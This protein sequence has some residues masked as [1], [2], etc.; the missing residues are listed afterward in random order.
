MIEIQQVCKRHRDSE[1]LRGAS[2]SVSK[3]QV[4][5]ILGASGSGKS[6]LMR[7]INGLES[8]ES[9]VIKVDHLQLHGTTS[10][11]ERART[12]KQIRKRVGMVFQGYHL[13]PHRSVLQNITEGPI[14]ISGMS[15]DAAEERAHRL[16]DLVGLSHRKFAR[17]TSLSGGEQQRVA[18]ARSLAMEPD[19]ML[20]D[21]PTSAL[22]PPMTREIV[23]VMKNL[24]ASGMTMVV[25]T[26]DMNFAR[27]VAD[28]VHILASGLIVESG[29]V[30]EVFEAP[31]TQAARDLI[32]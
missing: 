28:S 4:A 7:C 16:L 10:A 12:L 15:T 25:V 29:P 20:F 18:I 1:I 21:E 11:Q 19:A 14:Y 23:D 27:K 2:L 17:P 5:T 6:T 24:A 9:G 8:F 31:K 26:H 3:G 30:D 22:D 32:L 13:F